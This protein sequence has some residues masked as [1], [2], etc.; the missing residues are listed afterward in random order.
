MTHM[1]NLAAIT[2]VALVALA[3]VASAGAGSTT[4]STSWGDQVPTTGQ[5]LNVTFVISSFAPVVP[6]EY[7][8]QNTC[9]YPKGHFTLGQRDDIVAWTDTDPVSGNP[10]VTMPVYLQSVP[11]GATCKVALV[12]NNTVVK[13][14]AQTYTVK[15]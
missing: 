6:Y 11:V 2:G 15:P 12:S 14:S 7:A 13:G 4:A 1:R 10:Q 8:V 5:T 9:A 3:L